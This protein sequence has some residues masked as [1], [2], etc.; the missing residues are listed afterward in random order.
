MRYDYDPYMYLCLGRA[1]YAKCRHV[2][3]LEDISKLV[4][5]QELAMCHEAL[6]FVP[7]ILTVSH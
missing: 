6:S 5:A 7:M 1:V 3:D 2:Q 4:Y